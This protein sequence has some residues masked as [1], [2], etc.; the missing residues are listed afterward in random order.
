MT[1]ELNELEVKQ[2]SESL[3][4]TISNIE[5]GMYNGVSEESYLI[6]KEVYN[7]LKNK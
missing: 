6:L 7:K 1:V 3:R 2:V 5:L 4:A